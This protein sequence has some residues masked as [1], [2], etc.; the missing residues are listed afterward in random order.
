MAYDRLSSLEAGQTGGGYSDDPAFQDLQ[1]ELKNKLQSLLS[2]NRKL[3]NDVNVLGTKKD[4]PRLRERVHNTMEKSRE[5]CKD[6]G[7]GVKKLQ[8]WEDLTVSSDFQTALQEFQGLQ[9]KALEKER[10]SITAAREAQASEI[11]GAGGEEQLQLQQQQQLSQLAPQDEVDFQEALIIEREEEIRNIEQGVGD[12]NVLF[13]QVA[14]IVTEQGQQLITISDTVENIH[15]S[16]RG[17]DVETRQAARYQKAA[18]NKGCCL[19]LIL[20]I[21]LTIVLLA[22]FVG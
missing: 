4:T 22:I 10:A 21:I 8:T 16:T 2:N 15:E 12:L 17:A 13:K 18:R 3:A 6:I 1:Y 9:R 11:A 20:A 5:I 14:Q 19:L 7:D